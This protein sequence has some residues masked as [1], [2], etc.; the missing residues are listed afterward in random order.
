MNIK[1]VGATTFSISALTAVLLLS[2]CQTTPPILNGSGQAVKFVAPILGKTSMGNARYVLIEKSIADGKYLL[3]NMSMTRQPIT[4]ERQERI[5]F[6]HDLTGYAPDYTDYSFQ[7][8]TDSGNYDQKTVVMRCNSVPSKT[9][10]YNPCNSAFGQVFMPMGA[11]KAFVAGHMSNDSYNSWQDP[12][13]NSL[14]SVR[15]PEGALMQAGVF[16]RLPELSSAN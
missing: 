15:S 2:G 9:S 3:V 11:T 5:A 14:R 7:T 16:A 12:A 10:Q 6:T 1:I 4:N 13:R 8:H